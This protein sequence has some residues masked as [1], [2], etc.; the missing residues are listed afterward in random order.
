VVT[1]VP[2]PGAVV[3]RGSRLFAV[4]ASP[5]FLL[6]GRVPAYRAFTPGMTDG[7]DV[8]ELE[9][10][11]AALGMAP[12][13]VDRHFSAA[14]AAAVRRWQTV[15]RLP[16]ADRTG[17]L[18]LGRVVFLPGP[19]RIRQVTA[20]PGSSAGPGA[21]MLSATSTNQV[22][23]VELTTD[24]RSQVHVGDPVRVTVSGSDSA[25]TGRVRAIGRVA[26]PS[27][28]IPG[29]DT[30]P[31]T[32]TLV[33]PGGVIAGFDRAPV[34]VAITSARRRG[35]LTVPVTALLARPGGG[36]QVAVLNGGARTLL[37]VEPGLYDDDEG[38]VEVTG[39]GLREGARVEVPVP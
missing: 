2:A 21:T 20:G 3:V 38:T 7:G 13:T 31:M 14:T 35:V 9:R 30:V 1:A 11:L 17:R 34:E 36:Y 10:N 32:I 27:P 39:A 24:K 37:Q 16:V 22:V 26:T 12:G 29:T 23:S 5:A 6:Y 33:R 8:L 28:Q 4:G 15:R 25:I 19:I 18:E